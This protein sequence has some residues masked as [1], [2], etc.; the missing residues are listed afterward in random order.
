M[1]KAAISNKF[2]KALD[3]LEYGRLNLVTPEGRQMVFEGRNPG[4]NADINLTDWRVVSNLAAQGDVAFADDYRSGLW[5]TSNLTNLLLLGLQNDSRLNDF[6]FGGKLSH[7]MARL[8]YMM[9]LNTLKGSRRNIHAHYDLGNDFYALWLDSGMT[10]SSALY[11]SESD[12]LEQAQNNKY[13]RIL[14]RLDPSGRGNGSLLEIGSGW[15]GFAERAMGRGDYDIR[16]LTLSTEQLDFARQRLGNRADFALQDYRLEKG[17]F[18]H[19]VS[20][21]MFEA[22]G[23]RFWPAYFKQIAQTLNTKGRAVIQT[24]TIGEQYFDRYRRSGDM[25]RSFIFPGGMLPTPTRFYAEAQKAGLRVQDTF[26]FGH[27][28][29]HTLESWLHRFDDQTHAVKALG[30]DDRFIRLWRF[31]LAACIAGFRSGRTDVMQV[32]LA[33]E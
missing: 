8:V 9:R 27:D 16:G 17:K 5:D 7:I 33:H 31:Y 1:F 24:I 18:D 32:E 3:C 4:V 6:L 20:I 21:E 23:E 15:G 19:I 22:V 28:Y 11:H 2:F 29:A 14:D 13:D 30:F 25:I 26:F 10:Y 12:T